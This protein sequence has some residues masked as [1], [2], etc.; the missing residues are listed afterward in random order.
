MKSRAKTESMLDV[1]QCA[2]DE[3][4]SGIKEVLML[5]NT[6]PFLP[7]PLL[8]T[9]L[10]WTGKG[11]VLALEAE[12]KEEWFSF[13]SSD[14]SSISNSKSEIP[15][16]PAIKPPTETGMSVQKGRA[17]REGTCSLLFHSTCAKAYAAKSR[18][19]TPSSGSSTPNVF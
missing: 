6:I 14:A 4:D 16:V 18:I 3:N 2:M 9:I 12:K 7:G 10:S 17:E 15:S 13:K 19:A 8:K 1:T 5:G 11:A